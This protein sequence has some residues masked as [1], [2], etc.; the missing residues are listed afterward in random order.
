MPCRDNWEFDK[1]LIDVDAFDFSWHPYIEDRPYIYQF[2]T[3]WQKTGGPRYVAPGADEDAPIKYIDTRILKS[4]RLAKPKLFTILNDYK[5]KDFDYSWHPDETAEPFIYQFGNQFYPAEEMP[6]IQFRVIGAEN[7]AIAYVS[8]IVAT[9]GKDKRNWKVPTFLDVE[10][11][12]FSW[13]PNP[14]EPAMIHEF[15]TQHQKTGGPKYH[16]EG[17]TEVKHEDY[18]KA[19]ALP[20]MRNWEVPTYIDQETFDFSWHPDANSPPY[21]YR[22][23]TQWALSGGPVYTCDKATEVKY[24]EDI[25]ATALP[26]KEHW[27]YDSKLVDEDDFDYSWHPYIEDD[28][29]IYQFG[30]QHQK[31]GGHKYVGPGVEEDTATKYIDPR[32]LKS[33]RLP[34]PNSNCWKVLGNYQIKDFDYSWHHDET[35]DAFKYQFGSKYYPAEEMPTI[36]YTVPGGSEVKY[37]NDVVA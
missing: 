33:K 16:V 20:N 11:F 23:A 3:Q 31:T 4:K 6:T 17:A 21:I 1:L 10:N 29:F 35:E 37:I 8:D 9:L 18:A 19:V 34:N 5:I 12:D 26:N 14:N 22:F 13:K 7:D 36:E 15:G 2:G 27:V 30:T 25:V 24:I 32:I 28:P